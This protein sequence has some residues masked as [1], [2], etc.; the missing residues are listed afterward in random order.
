MWL[1]P[2]KT[3]DNNFLHLPIRIF[4]PNLVQAM[5]GG[6]FF[7]NAAYEFFLK[8]KTQHLMSNY[9][10]RYN[11]IYPLK[12]FKIITLEYK[13]IYWTN[14]SDMLLFQGVEIPDQIQPSNSLRI[15]ML[16]KLTSSCYYWYFTKTWKKGFLQKRR[17]TTT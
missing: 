5:T 10:A 15:S 16:L 9:I 1:S 8:H 17:N 4:H 13:V 6:N 3:C 14:L 2:C 11:I 12:N 7:R